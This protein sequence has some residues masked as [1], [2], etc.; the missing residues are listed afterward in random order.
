MKKLQFAMRLWVKFKQRRRWA[1]HEVNS[2]V[3][4]LLGTASFSIT[5]YWG[6]VLSKT[7]PN[8]V[9]ITNSYGLDALGLFLWL[10]AGALGLQVWVFGNVC[11][12]CNTIL[13]ERHF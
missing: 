7:V 5:A 11:W 6:M 9:E 3:L 2:L 10:I 1:Y 8:L 12:R 4:A 13:R